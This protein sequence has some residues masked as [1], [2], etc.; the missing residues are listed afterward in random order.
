MALRR[1]MSSAIPRMDA[2]DRPAEI[3]VLTRQHA[4]LNFGAAYQKPITGRVVYVCDVTYKVWEVG[5][6][7]MAVEVDAHNY[8]E[9]KLCSLCPGGSYLTPFWAN[10]CL[11]IRAIAWRVENEALF[12]ATPPSCRIMDIFVT[13]QR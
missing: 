8:G 5:W 12:T 9:L 7:V 1:V 13:R 6:K 2:A 11:C 4:S 3:V 10:I